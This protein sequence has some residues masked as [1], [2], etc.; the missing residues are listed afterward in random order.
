MTSKYILTDSKRTVFLQKVMPTIF[1]G[2]LIWLI[3]EILFGIVF[4]EIASLLDIGAIYVIMVILNAILFVIFYVVSRKGKN[5][6]GLIIYFM[7]AFTAGVLSVPIFIWLS[8]FS[9]YVHVFVSLAVWGTAIILIIGLILKDKFLTAGYFWLQ[10]LLIAIGIILVL[11]FYI[12]VMAIT[13]WIVILISMIYLISI[14]LIIM[15]Y[16]T[17][18]TKK[19]KDDF[20]IFIAFRILCFLLIFVVII[21]I[22]V[23]IIAAAI[24]GADAIG[25]SGGWSSSGKKKKK[26]EY[27]T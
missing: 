27:H 8:D 5:I 9:I 10:F 23:L 2:S 17:I 16:G 18:M 11:L 12:F 13:N 7:F 24:A 15:L 22:V 14:S 21:L 4:T 1:I 26:K 3:S 19:I 6:S 20:W 25:G